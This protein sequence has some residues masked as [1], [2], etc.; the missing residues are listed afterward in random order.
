M[1]RKTSFIVFLSYFPD[2]INFATSIIGAIQVSFP[3][4]H[5]I[6]EYY[7]NVFSSK[8]LK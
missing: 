2:F 4:L 7:R 3:L 1:H 8:G 6:K 5:I